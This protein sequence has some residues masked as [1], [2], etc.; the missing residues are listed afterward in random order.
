M[1]GRMYKAT[2]YANRTAVMNMAPLGAVSV[3]GAR[4]THGKCTWSGAVMKYTPPREYVGTSVVAFA[5]A[6]SDVEKYVIVHVVEVPDGQEKG[7]P[8][9]EQEVSVQSGEVPAGQQAASEATIKASVAYM[10][11]EARESL[12]KPSR[13]EVTVHNGK[14]AKMVLPTDDI[15]ESVDLKTGGDWDGA[16]FGHAELEQ[17]KLKHAV[18]S[19]SA[20]HGDV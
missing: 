6:G 20:S 1:P 9:S 16:T 7:A 3:T 2:M 12:E 14:P 4:T 15:S 10:S 19:A 18:N 17:V 11:P 8:G 13:A 5:D